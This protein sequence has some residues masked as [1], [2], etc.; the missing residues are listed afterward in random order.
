MTLL[1]SC[2]DAADKGLVTNY[3]EGGYKMGGGHLKFYPY[4]KGGGGRKVLAMQKGG[5]TQ[6]WGS[7]YAVAWSFSHIAMRGAHKVSTL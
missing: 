6:F 4:E 7:F 1:S 3:R 2:G 5:H